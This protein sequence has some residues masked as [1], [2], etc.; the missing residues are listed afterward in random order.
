MHP[1]VSQPNRCHRLPR[2]KLGVTLGLAT[3]AI[4]FVALP[5]AALGKGV[6]EGNLTQNPSFT[7]GAQGWSG[8]QSRVERVRLKKAPVGRFAARVRADAG[9]DDYTI[10]DNPT[11]REGVE[12]GTRLV[13]MAFVRG[14][15][16]TARERVNLV[17]RESTPGGQFVGDTV[18][19]V[20]L[21]AKRFRRVKAARSAT[22]NGNVFD[23]YVQRTVDA[24]ERDAFFVDA[25]SLAE[26]QRGGEEEPPDEEPPGEEEPPP[27]TGMTS[28]SQIA[29][30]TSQESPLFEHDESQY[31]YI[32][33]RD[34]LHN[35]LEELRAAHPE[36]EILLYKNVAFTLHEP[37]CPY[38]PFQGGGISYCG[39]N[40]NWFLHRSNGSRISSDGYAAQR[41]MNIGQAG[42]R[43]EWLES[44]SDRLSD[45]HNN[46]SGVEYDGVFMD[47]TNLYPGHGMDGQ[48]AELTDAQYRQAMVGFVH[49]VSNGI[50]DQGF[51]TAVNVGMN[52]WDAPARSATLEVAEDVDVVNREGFVRWGESGTLF[53]DGASDPAPFWDD[54]M[55]LAEDIQAR[56]AGL[57]TIVYGTAGD[58]QGQRYARASFLMA[59]DGNENSAVSYRV[60]AASNP[61][62]P[63][64]TTEVGTP[65]SDRYRVG[66]GWRRE[67]SGG[68][69]V[70][71]ARSSGSQAF[72]LGA[73]YR[74]ADGSCVNSV[75]LGAARAM[76]MPKC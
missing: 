66:Q 30:I 49:T 20:A 26:P 62:L 55:E 19:S 25:V 12:A 21:S 2:R 59:W 18:Q 42:Y 76:V 65:E 39:A 47:D 40:E 27:D 5:Q 17:I 3:A 41:A 75:S 69:V 63:D 32:I 28:T 38:D 33:I 13:G 31:R 56:G 64:W 52:P 35:R 73:D 10:D 22:T 51:K 54:E 53:T 8:F 6:P 24:A 44:V 48:I 34:S 29:I 58:V 71:N 72:G 9:V 7:Q 61:W 68:T 15:R 1:D 57:H 60:T 11:A 50:R 36:S 16:H 23:I 43:Q 4:G 14:A 70:I 45:A 46:G 74:A 37:G 67:F